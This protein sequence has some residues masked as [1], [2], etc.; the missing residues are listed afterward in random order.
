MSKLLEY[1]FSSLN[2]KEFKFKVPLDYSKPKLDQIEIF[3]R[4]ISNKKT[5]KHD[6]PYLLFFQGGPGFESPRPLANFGWIKRAII[7]YKV[8]LLDQRGTGLSSPI[9]N[10]SFFGYSDSD[11]ANYLTFFRADSIVKDAE[12]IR[13]KLIGNNKWAVLG[14]SFGGFCSLHYLSFYPDS[15]SKVF[16]TGGLPPID[17]HPDDIYR[18]TYKRVLDKN[19]IFYKKFPKSIDIIPK[20]ISHIRNNKEYLPNGDILTVK[21]FQQ[22]GLLLGFSDGMANINYLIENAFISAK[23]KLS[24]IFLK[25]FYSA[26]SFDTNPIFSVLHEACYAQNFSTNWS[27]NRILDEFPMFHNFP[28][29]QFYFTGEMIYPWIFDHYKDLKFL[30]NASKILARKSDWTF[31]YNKKNLENNTVPVVGLVYTNDMYVE[32]SYSIDCSN[33]IKNIIIWETDQ[34][35]HNGLRSHG[36]EILSKLFYLVK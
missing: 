14:Q 15:L 32:R 26:Q 10:Y 17:A 5:A 29:K 9:S 12:F 1:N 2:I 34:Y 36:E 22:L 7:D 11:I 25:N 21:R 18:S 28:D 4:E 24:Y 19:K 8:L 35:E 31:L 16:I 30:K 20:I 13:K 27:A 3:A 33:Y 23:N 6:L